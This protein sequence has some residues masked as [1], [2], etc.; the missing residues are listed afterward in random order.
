MGMV[1][2]LGSGVGTNWEAVTS[3]K[4]GIG[5]ITHFD[6]TGFLTRIAGEVKDGFDIHGAIPVKE[7]RRLDRHQQYAMVAA[8]EA[9]V[10]AG[11]QS[12]PPDP[13][14]C[15]VVIG[16]GMG[17]L[18]TMETGYDILKL[19]GPR[20]M[21]P[22]V[23]PMVV[24]SLIPGMLSMKYQF[25]G[26]NFG[27]VNACTSGA[28][29]IGE[30]FRLI[31]GGYADVA[32]TGGTEAVVS[33]LSIS[34]FNAIRA[35]STRNDEPQKA[36]RPFDRDRDGFVIAE[37]SGI[38]ILEAMDTAKARGANIFAELAGYGA[39]G[40]AYHIVMPEPEGS[41]AFNAMKLAL[42]EAGVTP[43]DVQYINAHGTSTELNDKIESLA[44]KRLFKDCAKEV[45]ISSTKS[46]TGHMIG[47]AGAVEAI[48]SVMAILNNTVPPTINLDNEDPE[49]DLHYTPHVSVSRR[50]DCAMSNSFAFGGQNAALVFKRA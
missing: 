10:S 28:S 4:S 22:F 12:P 48:Y 32:M 42:D 25:K 47:A 31:A 9:F 20:K 5:E 19:K 2:C 36:S 14:R 21:P 49:C 11:L 45:S 24:I 16:S 1:T 38:L 50:I 18:E 44:I 30:A 13:Y 37:G 33:S 27:V 15:A 3:G 41:G 46:M 26:P 39:T 17:G 35:L 40:D 7:L 43:E 34:S 6:T 23:I 8:H 29:A